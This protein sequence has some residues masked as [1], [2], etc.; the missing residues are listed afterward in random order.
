MT[1]AVVPMSASH[2]L[3]SQVADLF[4]DYRGHYGANPAPEA[5][6]RWLREQLTWDRMR[7]YGAVD[8]DKAAGF[9]TVA[10]V[11]AALTLRTVWMIRDFYIDPAHRGGGIGRRLLAYVMEVARDD[12]AHRLTLQTENGNTAAEA[13]YASF[14][15]EPVT[16]MTSLSRHL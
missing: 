11:P 12:G 14:G 16:G 7:M 4:D 5:T 6:G 9:A 13:L 10:V 15:F 1:L 8:G 3:F 2:A